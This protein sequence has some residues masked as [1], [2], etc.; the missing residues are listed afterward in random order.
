MSL[1]P[2]CN[3][4]RYSAELAVDLIPPKN[5]SSSHYISV[6]IILSKSIHNLPRYSIDLV[7]TLI[8]PVVTLT[9]KL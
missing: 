7:V 2:I 6:H 8:D 4:P 9:S 3:L 1:K 5:H